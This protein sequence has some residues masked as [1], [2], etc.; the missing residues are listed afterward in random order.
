M[1]HFAPAAGLAASLVLTFAAPAGAGAPGL[2]TVGEWNACAAAR[3]CPFRLP[4][5]PGAPATEVSW[6]DA[7]LYLAWLSKRTGRP[8]R[9]PTLAEWR[10]RGGEIAE[11]LDDCH[12]VT[13]APD[14][15]S[16]SHRLIR[17]RTEGGSGA[18]SPYLRLTDVGFAAMPAD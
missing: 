13:D 15:V 7:Q 10:P 1:I 16:C 8:Y 3:A 9:L 14:G 4:G 17:P 12:P 11:W 6:D 5:R 18:Y 2:V